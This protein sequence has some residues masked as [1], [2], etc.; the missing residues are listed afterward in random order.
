MLISRFLSDAGV[1]Q[2][3]DYMPVGKIKETAKRWLVRE[4]GVVRGRMSFQVELVPAFNYARDEHRVEIERYGCRFISQRLTMELRTTS[5]LGWE[6]T[7]D[8]K[9]VTCLLELNEN[10]KETFVFC[11]SQRDE[12]GNWV[13]TEDDEDSIFHPGQSSSAPNGEQRDCW[14]EGGAADHPEGASAN[15]ASEGEKSEGK[16]GEAKAAPA[17]DSDVDGLAKTGERFKKSLGQSIVWKSTGALRQSEDLPPDVRLSKPRSSRSTRSEKGVEQQH[18][19]NVIE[20]AVDAMEEEESSGP[21]TRAK[22][23]AMQEKAKDGED[24]GDGEEGEEEEDGKALSIRPVPVQVSERLQGV[25]IG[26]WRQWIAKCSYNGRWREVVYRSALV[27]KLMTFEP[28]GA[29]V[30]ALTTSLPEEVGGERSR[31]LTHTHRAASFPVTAAHLLMWSCALHPCLTSE[32]RL[33]LPLHL[34]PR[35]FVHAVRLPQAG[36]QGGGLRLH[37]LDQPAMQGEREAGRITADHVRSADSEHLHTL[38]LRAIHRPTQ[39]QPCALPPTALSALSC[40]CA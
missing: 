8:G 20:A 1:G 10:E 16:V 28:T 7:E 19:S 23:E 13:A 5:A 6:L 24:N 33:G 11:Q 9:G 32:R 15:K 12:D 18:A 21:V 17:V 2:V 38:A 30:A 35:Q 14:N 3:M 31:S 4:L 22:A 29:I 36:L 39:P 34:D 25:T 27:L 26:F 40:A 37:A